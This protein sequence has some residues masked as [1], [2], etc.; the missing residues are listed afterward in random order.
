MDS[1]DKA[2]IK[3]QSVAFRT[4]LFQLFVVPTMSMDTELDGGE[5]ES[6][7][8][9]ELLAEFREAALNGSKTLK[10]MFDQRKPPTTFWMR[11][12][13]SLKEAA[14]HADKVAA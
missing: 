7:A 5:E 1:G 6:D 11:N 9:A 2:V 13:A 4:A 14:A 12:S 3:A 8:D 10:A